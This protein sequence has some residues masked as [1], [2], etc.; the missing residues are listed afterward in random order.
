V[1]SDVREKIGQAIAAQGISILP[2]MS[3]YI[4]HIPHAKQAAFLSPVVT[5]IPEVFFGG[6]AGGGKSD[7]LLMAALQYADVPGYAAIIF[8][9]TFTDLALQGA[10]MTRS[11]EWLDGS[12]A[13]WNER[14]HR[15]AFPSGASLSFGYL[16]HYDEE[17]RYQSAEF[18]FIGFDEVTDFSEKAYRFMFSRLRRTVGVDAPLR[19]RSASNPVGPGK[20][21]VEQR[22]LVSGKE[23]GRLF[24]PS[25]LEDN[26]SLDLEE[27]E[28]ALHQL[29][30]MEYKQLRYGDW[31]VR[32]EG[33][34]FKRAWFFTVG[35]E[36]IPTDAKRVRFWD[37][38]ATGETPAGTRAK[39]VRDADW[40]VGL[41]LAR[42]STGV[43]YIEDVVRVRESPLG[44][45]AVVRE[46]AE[47]DGTDVAIR[48][49]QEGGASGPTVVADYRR[50]VLDGFDFKG[51]HPNKKK[52]ERANP[53]ASR[54]EAGEVLLIRGPWIEAFLDEITEFPQGVH[55]DQ[56]DAL[57]GAYA[58]LAKAGTT[59]KAVLPQGF[60]AGSHWIDR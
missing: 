20:A 49:E 8:R 25:R 57:S 36:E 13:R 26:P 47:L 6:A 17:K 45:R 28:K 60:T 35:K 55:D 54:A 21:W 42:S 46:T 33:N 10:I 3:P 9:R 53:I 31:A 29:E 16:Q 50:T 38:A 34:L 40:T 30:G 5:Q 43:Y 58:A 27:Y 22:F 11:H 12:D 52:E 41:R 44:V 51:V 15:W 1:R 37:L 19:M 18:Q 2:R 32:T 48:M 7:A 23:N 56:V 59:A 14:E 24:I 39:K 4:P